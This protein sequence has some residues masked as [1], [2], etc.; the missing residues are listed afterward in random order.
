VYSDV[1]VCA[2]GYCGVGLILENNDVETYYNA[3]EANSPVV[4]ATCVAGTT[5]TQVSSCPSGFNVTTTCDGSFEGVVTSQCSY[6]MT[7]PYCANL[8]GSAAMVDS[9]NV[10]TYDNLTTICNCYVT[11]MYLSNPF[12]SVSSYSSVAAVQFV[13][14]TDETLITP[15]SVY[16]TYSPT[17]S[18]SAAPSMQPTK[19]K[20]ENENYYSWRYPVFVVL[21]TVS[22]C[23]VSCILIMLWSAITGSSLF[24]SEEDLKVVESKDSSASGM[25]LILKYVLS[26][27]IQLS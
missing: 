3:T 5:S 16:V 1:S 18:P 14:T 23:I 20:N 11:D 17:S 25:P 21:M 4:S 26:L 2:T 27:L 15:S 24:I 9:C 12:P 7:E 8:I 22:V 10:T 13:S 6:F 19:K